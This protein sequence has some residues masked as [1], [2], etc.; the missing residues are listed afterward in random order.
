VPRKIR[1][2]QIEKSGEVAFSAYDNFHPGCIVFGLAVG[3]ELLKS[4][5]SQGVLTSCTGTG[6][7]TQIAP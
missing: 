5:E 7:P 3:S 6:A 1:H 4:L 2:I